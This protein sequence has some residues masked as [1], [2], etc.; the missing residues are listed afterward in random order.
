ME[1]HLRSTGCHLPYGITQ[2]YLPPDTS[3]LNPAI[4]PGRYMTYLAGGMEGWVD[5]GDWLHIEMV[6]PP[7]I[8]LT[9]KN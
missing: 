8:K 2:S 7:T 3:E 5:L 4:T 6:Y 9:Q 1:L